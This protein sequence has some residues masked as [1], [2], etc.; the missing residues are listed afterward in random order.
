MAMLAGTLAWTPSA[1]DIARNAAL[2]AAAWLA[3]PLRFAPGGRAL[4]C[5]TAF[6]LGAAAYLG[7][8]ADPPLWAGMGL[9][10]ATAALAWAAR[11]SWGARD[12]RAFG[13][14]LA[15]FLAA[16][17][18]AADLRTRA[19]TEPR[20]EASERARL[21]T[22]WVERIDGGERGRQR[23]VVRVHSVLG[24]DEAPRRVRVS[25]QAGAA[26]LGDGVALRAVLGPPPGPAIPGGYDFARS[27]FFQ[28]IGGVGYAVAAPRLIDLADRGLLERL[29]RG[30]A[31]LRGALSARL[32][33]AGGPETGPVLAALVTGER[34]SISQE[35]NEA[36]RASGLGHALSIS[37]M[38]MALVGGGAFAGLAFLLASIDRLARRRD[39]RK[40]AAIGALLACAGYLAIS[41][42]GIPTQRAFIMAAA[43]FLAVL[44]NRR[45][46]SL[47]TLASA[48]MVALVW[49]P[50]SATDPGFQMSF[51]ATAALIGAFQAERARRRE[52]WTPP[53]RGPAFALW[54][55]LGGLSMTSLVAGLATAP[56]AAFH[57]N[58]W[59]NYALPANLAA[60]PIFT[61]V[62]MP[63]AAA[64]AILAPLGLHGP[65][66]AIADLGLQTVL[67]V[68]RLTA[69]WSGAVSWTPNAPGAALLLATGAI[70]AS[71]ALA[72][73][74]L[75]AGAALALGAALVWQ[76]GPR[77]AA[78]IG[79]R[80]D[81]VLVSAEG[82]R[83]VQLFGG[84]GT[85]ESFA[86]SSLAQAA[87]LDPALAP[88]PLA[89][90]LM[91]DAAGC[92]G[93]LKGRRV[94]L[95]RDLSRLAEDC[96][97]ADLVI[98]E[99]AP[100]PRLAARCPPGVLVAPPE[101][102]QR[103]ALHLS[104]GRARV[105]AAGAGQR[106]WSAPSR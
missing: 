97:R 49:R 48:A 11:A 27:A 7:L 45:A 29:E 106:P 58:R 3:A 18:L 76:V 56:Y 33:A 36:F 78:L 38:H 65:F 14:L 20:V 28:E 37:G 66:A 88:K 73:G 84:V 91:C 85:G 41:G 60:M 9:A 52:R 98:A 61:F 83:G 39:P 1:R 94:A 32:Q 87:G 79:A 70:L 25:A 90:L 26:G 80:G 44:V 42:G 10:L 15:A 100:P 69:G 63:A 16:G 47:H 62:V 6:G 55:T 71:A 53:R 99:K 8:S 105:E 54:R 59:A 101:R 89:E 2:R 43:A 22:G 23:Y 35:T 95:N 67:W 40:L 5:P 93:R 13:L 34:G 12:G 50:E 30:L 24:Q 19:L 102:G 81:V 46:I 92:A 4:L 103:L 51:A 77:P 64:A 68:A 96:A 74:R 86:V 21:V 17:F 57:F 104:K 75:R 82:G 72:Q 31:K